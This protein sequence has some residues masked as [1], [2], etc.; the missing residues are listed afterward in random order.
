VLG[1]TSGS[2]GERFLCPLKTHCKVKVRDGIKERT[3]LEINPTQALIVTR[4]F[5]MVLEGK[6]FLEVAEQ[7]NF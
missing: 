4:I 1:Y 2:G 6:G 5:T 7:L 3:K